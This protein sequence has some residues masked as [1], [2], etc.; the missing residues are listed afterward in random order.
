M[1]ERVSEM[2]RNVPTILVVRTKCTPTEDE[3]LGFAHTFCVAGWNDE[4]IEVVAQV[5]SYEAG[6]TYLRLI[7]GWC[8]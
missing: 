6:K 5:Q 2:V 7:G 8:I 1:R 4:T 3:P